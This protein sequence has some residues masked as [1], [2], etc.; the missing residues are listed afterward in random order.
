MTAKELIERLK[1][2][3]ADAPVYAWDVCND[4][5]TTKVTVDSYQEG[6]IIKGQPIDEQLLYWLEEQPND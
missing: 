6:L 1:A 4:Y 2:Y 5:F 3:P